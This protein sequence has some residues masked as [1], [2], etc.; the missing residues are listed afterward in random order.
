M[1]QPKPQQRMYQNFLKLRGGFVGV[2]SDAAFRMG[3]NCA[4]LARNEALWQAIVA[5]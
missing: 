4:A 3:L 1:E 2:K 5:L